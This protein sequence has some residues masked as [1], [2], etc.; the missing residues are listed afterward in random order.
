MDEKPDWFNGTVVQRGQ[1]P[2]IFLPIDTFKCATET[3]CA[4]IARVEMLEDSTKHFIRPVAKVNQGQCIVHIAK[5]LQEMF[6][7]GTKCKVSVWV[8]E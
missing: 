1:Q 4:T 3:E 5:Q 8:P 6:V 7:V 2:G